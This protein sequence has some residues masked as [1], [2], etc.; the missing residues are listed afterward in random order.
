MSAKNQLD[1]MLIGAVLASGAKRVQMLQKIRQYLIATDPLILN[2]QLAQ[3]TNVQELRMLAAAGVPA[4]LQARFYLQY[5]K[6]L[7]EGE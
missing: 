3:I 4:N 6:A 7:H 2:E 1:A 5:N